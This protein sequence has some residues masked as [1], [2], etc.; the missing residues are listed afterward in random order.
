MRVGPCV[1][2]LLLW[3]SN[4]LIYTLPDPW[5]SGKWVNGSLL[6]EKGMAS[7]IRRHF[8][9]KSAFMKQLAPIKVAFFFP[10]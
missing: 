8:L 6:S 1:F 4:P 5:F 7:S 10:T 9:Q 3:D 2:F